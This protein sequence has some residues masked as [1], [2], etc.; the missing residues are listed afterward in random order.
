MRL[1][2]PRIPPVE[3][4]EATGEQQELLDRAAQRRGGRV[5]NIT[6]T[7]V[8][9]P[10]L[11]RA[12]E[13]II[14]HIMRD[15]TLTARTREILIL[16]VGWLCQ[17][18]YEFGQHTRFG[19]AAGLSDEEV[20]RITD[21]PA[22]K[23]W[24]PFEATLLRAVDELHGDHFISNATWAALSERYNTQ[25]LMDLVFTVGQYTLVCMALN[26]FGVQLEEGTAGFPD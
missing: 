12:R 21:G 23:G 25:Q 11:A 13:P 16:R 7:M 10:A 17:A 14:D 24:D 26:T 2:K 1:T 9:H 19:K 3:A 5:L 6:R 4:S 8:Q 15:T 18:Q 20:R 22:A